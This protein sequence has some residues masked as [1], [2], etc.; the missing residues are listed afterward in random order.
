VYAHKKS[1]H[2]YFTKHYAHLDGL[3]QF[4]NAFRAAQLEQSKQ[5]NAAPDVDQ[6]TGAPAIARSRSR[7]FRL[8][9]GERQRAARER[10]AGEATDQLTKRFK[11][12]PMAKRQLRV[13][14][15]GPDSKP[16]WFSLLKL[17]AGF[18]S[19]TDAERYAQTADHALRL[20]A[21][22]DKESG[23]SID[24]P[25]MLRID[26]DGRLIDDDIVRSAL[27]GREA[28]RIRVCPICDDV[29]IARRKD[30]RA[31]RPRCAKAY[32]QRKLR[33]RRRE[34]ESHRPRNRQARKA[35]QERDRRH[36]SRD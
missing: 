7:K 6:R 28:A 17:P 4:A 35:K 10:F 13:Y 34:Y 1:R 8:L 19:T 16:S 36:S 18:Y 23:A 3:A 20:I 25:S 29:F 30:Q 15:S 14:E 24:L 11:L 5:G 2:I 33:E 26:A 31:C 22:A 12:R 9:W 21:Q 27:I 32:G